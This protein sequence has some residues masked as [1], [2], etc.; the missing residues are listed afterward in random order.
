MATRY[1]SLF[2]VDLD[3]DTEIVTT[4]APKRASRT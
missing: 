2:D 4:I 1:K 3:P